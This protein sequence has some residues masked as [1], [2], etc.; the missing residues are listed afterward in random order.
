MLERNRPAFFVFDPP[1]GM[2]RKFATYLVLHGVD[3]L[4]DK[5]DKTTHGLGFPFCPPSLNSDP[6]QQEAENRQTISET[7]A[8]V[9]RSEGKLDTTKNHMIHRG[10]S[11]AFLLLIYQRT[12]VPF[13]LLKDCFNG[14]TDNAQYLLRNCTNPEIVLRFEYYHALRGQQRQ[15]EV[16]P[17]ERRLIEICGC[18]QLRKRCQATF[19]LE[20][21]INGGG[22]ALFDGSSLNNLSRQDAALIMGMVL[23][24]LIA[25]ARSGRL[26]RR[27]VIVIDEGLNAGI[28]DANITRA[29]KEAGKWGIE[30]H[31][32]TQSPLFSDP[33]ITEGLMMCDV[34]YFFKQI[35]PKA[36]M[37]AAEICGT[38]TLDPLK[39]KE[40]ITRVHKEHAGVD[41]QE[42]ETSSEQF[43]PHGKKRGGGKNKGFIALPI[44]R[45]KEEQQIVRQSLDDQIKLMAQHFM[46]LG[47]GET[48][49]KEGS[50]VVQPPGQLPMLDMP[51]RANDPWQLFPRITL[52]ERKLQVYLDSLKT[53][54]EFQFPLPFT[55]C[56]PKK[57]R[58]TA[59]E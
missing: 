53:R 54:P 32:I 33:E 13:Y 3:F 25:L 21:F 1:G 47:V 14:D 44:Y 58:R 26:K 30:F 31:L 22:I 55:T 15:F 28:I 34:I 16:G 39:V 42:I 18:P 5:L 10:L 12:P 57:Q 17:A 52:G 20:A 6:D 50:T 8:A 23:L 45:D 7:N 36:A 43:D 29:L 19:D 24:L 59:M 40:I 41:I 11:D 37:F 49:I 2:A 56:L 27:L 35:N 4:L 9:V 38:M 46:L 48:V 51:L